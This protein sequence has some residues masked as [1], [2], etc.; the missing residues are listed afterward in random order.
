M[1]L[2]G[3]L[4][5]LLCFK[6]NSLFPPPSPYCYLHTQLFHTHYSY[7]MDNYPLCTWLIH[8]FLKKKNLWFHSSSV[9]NERSGP[10]KPSILPSILTLLPNFCIIL[11]LFF[12]NYWD[13][14]YSYDLNI[15]LAM[16]QWKRSSVGLWNF[17]LQ[18]IMSV[19]GLLIS[20]DFFYIVTRNKS[21]RLTRSYRQENKL[22]FFD[23]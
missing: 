23:R 5:R 19:N 2:C 14:L 1:P 3:A 9:I 18:V 20:F 6:I 10:R 16:S 21:V 4:L 11:H 7:S 12:N 15:A 8:I 22:Q 17:K 13:A